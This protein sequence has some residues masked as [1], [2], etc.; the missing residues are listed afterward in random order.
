MHQTKITV[1]QPINYLERKK[2]PKCVSFFAR[3]IHSTSCEM[4]SRKKKV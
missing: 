4:C 1:F 3:P 2:T